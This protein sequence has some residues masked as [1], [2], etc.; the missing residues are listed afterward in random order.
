MRRAKRRERRQ[1]YL[2][3]YLERFEPDPA[4]HDQ[5]TQAALAPL[6]AL[7]DDLAQIRT[8]TGRP[9]PDVIT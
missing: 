2:D 8:R 4:R 6:I 1:Q 5:E 9:G 3:A 7:A